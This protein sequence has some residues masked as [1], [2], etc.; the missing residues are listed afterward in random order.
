[1]KKTTACAVS[2]LVVLVCVLTI[3]A[4]TY[5]GVPKGQI[6]QAYVA[7]SDADTIVVKPGYGEC[8]G[9]YFEITSDLVYDVNDIPVGEDF[10]YIYIDDDQSDYPYPTIC[11][12]TTEPVWSD[13]KLGWYNGNDRCIGVVWT[14]NA[15]LIEFSNNIDNKY[16]GTFKN[17]VVNG[18]AP[19]SFQPLECSAYVPVNAKAVCFWGDNWDADQY[20]S[21]RICAYE[22]IWSR[23][24]ASGY[25]QAR[26]F[27]WVELERGASRDF[28]YQGDS[29]AQDDANLLN[30]YIRGYQIER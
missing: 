10:I 15:N 18:T 24:D 29:S 20:A 8:N 2:A 7:Y 11:D 4:G 23:I 5:V 6:Y 26:I 13:S 9:H 16:F 12:S 19:T 28:K 21:L 27:G 17:V 25:K 1:M 22:N 14:N 3:G 30:I